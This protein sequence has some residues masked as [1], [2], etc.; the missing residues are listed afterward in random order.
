M[1]RVIERICLIA[2]MAGI[3]AGPTPD[4]RA[5]IQDDSCIYPD[6]EYPIPCDEDD[7]D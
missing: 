1:R 5:T 7:D 3:F 4:A 6:V 2:V